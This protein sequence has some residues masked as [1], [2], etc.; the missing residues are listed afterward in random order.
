MRWEVR[1]RYNSNVDPGAS[2]L[3]APPPPWEAQRPSGIEL[4]SYLPASV[5]YLCCR[6]LLLIVGMRAQR[7]YE[8]PVR[9]APRCFSPGFLFSH[10]DSVWT[11]TSC[12]KHSRKRKRFDNRLRFC[13]DTALQQSLSLVFFSFMFYL[14]V[15]LARFFFFGVFYLLFGLEMSTP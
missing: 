3:G 9:C 4:S 13:S 15:I 14:V 7:S 5:L 10:F 8:R 2:T 12:L 11:P 6:A 1:A